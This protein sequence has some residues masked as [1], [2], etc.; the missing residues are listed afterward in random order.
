VSEHRSKRASRPPRRGVCA[1]LLLGCSVSK[2]ER[3]ERNRP[4]S[5]GVVFGCKPSMSIVH[6]DSAH[7]RKVRFLSPVAWPP[8]SRDPSG[9]VAAAGPAR[10]VH[11]SV[12]NRISRAGPPDRG[13]G[14]A[15]VTPRT[16]PQRCP[17]SVCPCNAHF[18]SSAPFGSQTTGDGSRARCSAAP[19]Q[20]QSI[21]TMHLTPCQAWASIRPIG[22][23]PVSRLGIPSLGKIGK[24]CKSQIR[25]RGFSPVRALLA[26]ELA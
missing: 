16:R 2:R 3:V 20:V 25:T 10:L 19:G 13:P 4:F 1:G 26:I 11:Y 7:G 15:G 6:A 14:L 18:V 22:C 23:N 24:R 21:Q 8:A 5:T 17:D 9:I 12:A